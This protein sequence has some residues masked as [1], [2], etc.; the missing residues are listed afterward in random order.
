MTIKRYQSTI[1]KNLSKLPQ[2]ER[3][4][5]IKKWPSKAFTDIKSICKGICNNP[6][7]NPSTLKK[8]KP[9]KIPI[10]SIAKSNSKQVKAI[11]LRQRGRGIFTAIAAG[12]I[13]LIVQGISGLFKKKP[14]PKKK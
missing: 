13:P 6:K 2:K 5:H 7:L 4:Q 1:F 11:L 10:R 12:I 8:I 14:K 9:Y 3:N